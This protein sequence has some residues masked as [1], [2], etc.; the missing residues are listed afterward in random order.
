MDELLAAAPNFL[1]FC[2]M[3]VPVTKHR[4]SPYQGL[5][6][7]ARQKF[8]PGLTY[9]TVSLVHHPDDWQICRFKPPDEALQVCHHSKEECTDLACIVNQ[10]L[11]SKLFTVSGHGEEFKE[12]RDAP[13]TLP[14]IDSYPDGLFSSNFE[15]NGEVTFADLA[16]VVL[17]V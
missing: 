9:V 3:H 11:P 8:V 4:V 13:E 10:T 5:K 12:D 7:N 16:S 2:S 17:Q 6:F 15:K 14:V 1:L